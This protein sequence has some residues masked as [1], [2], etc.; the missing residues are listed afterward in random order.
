MES[1]R[2]TSLDPKNS[3][4]EIQKNAKTPPTAQAIPELPN[5]KIGLPPTRFEVIMLLKAMPSG[6]KSQ[7][8]KTPRFGIVENTKPT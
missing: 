6:L 4:M 5:P 3:I 7:L 2:L 8:P 1:Q